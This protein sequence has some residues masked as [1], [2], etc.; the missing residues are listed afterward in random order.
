MK[1]K[2]HNKF[3]NAIVYAVINFAV[4]INPAFIGLAFAASDNPHNSI[5]SGQW[6][7]V[8]KMGFEGEGLRFPLNIS[9]RNKPEKL[10][11][12]LPVPGT[13][14]KVRLEEYVP[15]LRWETDAVKYSGDGIAAKLI[16]KGKDLEQEVWLGSANPAKQSMSSAVG[17]IAIR[18]LNNAETAENL[19]GEL[20]DQKAI[21]IL[22]VRLNDS[23]LPFECAARVS[24][25]VNVPQSR[26]SVTVLEYMPHYSIDTATKKIVNLSE[27][28]INP[29]V[30]V[31]INDG[32][33]T[34]EQWLW[35]KFPLSPHQKDDLPLRM[36][37]TDF[38]AVKAEGKYF[39]IVASGKAP[40]LLLSD[41]G[42]KRAEKASIGR[43]YLFTNNEYSFS[44]EKIIDGAIIE[45]IWKN[46]SEKLVNPALIT[47]IEQGEINQQT[48][49]EFNKPVHYKTDFG[50]LV[51][52][53]RHS[54]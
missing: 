9:D 12:T 29:A 20:T 16:I 51:L 4:W 42:K 35:A 3:C 1:L 40:W 27:N 6:E 17:G 37:F 21:G 41:K 26:Y 32:A 48:V 11:I 38:D 25:T 22:S 43:P 31:V 13:A 33:K 28:P 45:T 5:L 30:K 34:I 19:V 47:T 23:N 18:K 49:L 54:P 46:N 15:D 7:L 36:Q 52:L 14:V 39:L 8:I 24:Q 44:I 53:Y 2:R 50:T 10:N